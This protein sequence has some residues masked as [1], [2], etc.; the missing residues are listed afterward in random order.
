VFDGII[1]PLTT[2][3]LGYVRDELQY[4]T[5]RRYRLINGEVSRRWDWGRSGPSSSLGASD[6]LRQGLALN[7]RL[8]VVI[9]HGMTDIVTPY[10]A[11]RYVVDHLPPG[12]T[13]DRVAVR[14]HPGGHMMYLRPESRAALREDARTIYGD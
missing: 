13:K 3:F 4:R 2:A 12:L 14:L 1:A 8:K 10:M 7:P 6:E 9:E 5:D 11:S